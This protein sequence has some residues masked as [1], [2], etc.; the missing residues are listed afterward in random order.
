MLCKALDFSSDTTMSLL[1]LG[2]KDHLTYDARAGRQRAGLRPPKRVETPRSLG[3]STR[4]RKT[5]RIPTAGRRQP[6]ASG[7][8]EQADCSSPSRTRSEHVA[9]LTAPRSARR[10]HHA[11]TA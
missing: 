8:L 6:R 5:A 3:A 7:P 10:T 4:S 11:V 9:P 2:A 1:F